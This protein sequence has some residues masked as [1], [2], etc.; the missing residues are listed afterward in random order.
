MLKTV[1]M[2]ATIHMLVGQIMAQPNCDFIKVA[3][4]YAR[5]RW[6]VDL[7]TDRRVVTWLEGAVTK[8]AF[9]LPADAL[10]YVPEIGVDRE[11][12]RVVSAKLWPI[13]RDAFSRTIRGS[14][15]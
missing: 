10:G 8:V 6:P 13:A 9:E 5:A 12:C 2:T 4:D 3:E 14:R 7:T 11:T 1:L 15:W